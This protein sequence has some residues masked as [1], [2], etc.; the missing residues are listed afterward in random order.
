MKAPYARLLNHE[1]ILPHPLFLHDF[2][3]Y[4][5]FQIHVEPGDQLQVALDVS[6]CRLIAIEVARLQTTEEVQLCHVFHRPV[7]M[8]VVEKLEDAVD[9]TRRVIFDQEGQLVD[10]VGRK[11]GVVWVGHVILIL[12]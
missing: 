11:L 7:L 1:Y 5:E 3:V 8:G 10:G 9:G 2:P 4:A 12:D 6:A